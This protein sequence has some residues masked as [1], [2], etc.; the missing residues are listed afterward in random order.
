MTLDQLRQAMRASG[1]TQ[2]WLKRLAEN[3]NSKNQ[4]YLGPDLTA[5]NILPIGELETHFSRSLEC[6]VAAAAPVA[7]ISDMPLPKSVILLAAAS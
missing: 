7:S 4:V 1:V 6:H 2:L 3:D 5:L